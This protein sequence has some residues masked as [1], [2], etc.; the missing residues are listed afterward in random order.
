M[1]NVRQVTKGVNPKAHAA[2]TLPALYG[3][4]TEYA[5]QVYDGNSHPALGQTPA[6][7]FAAGLERGGERLNRRVAY[8]DSFKMLTLPTTAR[9]VAKVQPGSG[10]KINYI[11]YWASELGSPEVEKSLL[12]V[13]Y[14]PFDLSTAYVFVS[15]RWTRCV[16]A[17]WQAFRGRSER[18]LM[19]ASAIL[20]R[21]NRNQAS[22]ERALTAKRLAE[23]DSPCRLQTSRLGLC[24]CPQTVRG[25]DGC[26]QSIQLRQPVFFVL[27]GT[28]SIDRL[29]PR[30][31]L[32]FRP[33]A[34]PH[35]PGI[36]RRLDALG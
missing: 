22:K 3:R 18:E 16:S 17:H 32:Q 2:W 11:Y 12:P 4:L 30:S 25:R 9:G 6:E 5:Y 27:R 23:F 34:R 31:A 10:V 29:T 20:H 19:L 28:A 1:R 7:A 33:S 26:S 14:D 8:D 35:P 13:R 15:G 21:L 36:L 24:V